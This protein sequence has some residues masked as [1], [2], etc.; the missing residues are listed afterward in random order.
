MCWEQKHRKLWSI[1]TKFKCGTIHVFSRMTQSFWTLNILSAF[2]KMKP[3]SL[4]T[5]VKTEIVSLSFLWKWGKNQWFAFIQFEQ[6]LLAD[7]RRTPKFSKTI[8]WFPTFYWT[9]KTPLETIWSRMVKILCFQKIVR[10]RWT[11]ELLM[12]LGEFRKFKSKKNHFQIPKKWKAQCSFI[13]NLLFFGILVYLS[14]SFCRSM[15]KIKNLNLT[16]QKL[17]IIPRRLSTCAFMD[18]LCLFSMKHCIYGI[19]QSHTRKF[20]SSKVQ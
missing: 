19:T 17:F 8:F 6:M 3:T 5:E 13:L 11:K 20:Q 15:R 4:K 14:F 1:S 7:S 9:G 18:N 16:K 2:E 10:M 12:I